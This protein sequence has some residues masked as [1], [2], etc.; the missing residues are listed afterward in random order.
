[1]SARDIQALSARHTGVGFDQCLVI[2]PA[3]RQTVDFFYRIYNADGQSVGQCGNGARCIARFIQYY[4]LSDKK[5]LQVA[6]QTTRLSLQLNA[7]ESVTVN[8]GTPSLLAEDIPITAH[9]RAEYYPITLS[10][11]ESYRVH[12]LSVGN[13]HA[14]VMTDKVDTAPVTRVG[15]LISAHAFFPLQANVSFCAIQAP[16]HIQLRVYE[17]GCGETSA[18]GSGAVAAVA[19]GRLFHQLADN[20]R[21][22]LPGGDLDVYWPASDGAIFLT[23]P[24]S[25]VYEG[26]LLI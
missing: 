26:Q 23:G 15:A 14:I 6:T 9:T 22:S 5:N 24:A 16:N 13:P 21:V 3:R 2:E 1:L 19:A 17:R 18:C 11:G 8:M 25:F 4:Q 20:V 7:D 12:A 10:T